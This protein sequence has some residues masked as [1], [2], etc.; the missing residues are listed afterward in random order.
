[1]W[2]GNIAGQ[3]SIAITAALVL[4]AIFL[5]VVLTRPMNRQKRRAAEDYVG[6]PLELP[7]PARYGAVARQ[8]GLNSAFERLFISTLEKVLPVDRKVELEPKM[9]SRDTL[10]D[11][12]V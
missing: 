7:I 10:R 4:S 9:M 1:M 3:Y 12:S 6:R 11:V 5:P 2:W 8:V